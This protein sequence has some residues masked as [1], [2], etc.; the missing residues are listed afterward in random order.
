M[1]VHE[2]EHMVCIWRSEDSFRDV[3][4]SFHSGGSENLSHMVRLRSLCLH[5]ISHL[6][7]P[8]ISCIKKRLLIH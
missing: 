2:C 8:I 7:G 5:V 1:H 4:L 6:T 3:V